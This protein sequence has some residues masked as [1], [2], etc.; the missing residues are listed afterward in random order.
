[1][2]AGQGLPARKAELG[3]PGALGADHS[4]A[5]ERA[6][7]SRDQPSV[8]GA[9]KT[10]LANV[11]RRRER[12]LSRSSSVCIAAIFMVPYLTKSTPHFTHVVPAACAW[13]Q[14]GHTTRRGW[15]QRRQ[16]CTVSPFGAPHLRHARVTALVII[17]A[18]MAGAPATP[19]FATVATACATHGRVPAVGRLVEPPAGT[20]GAESVATGI[21]IAPSGQTGRRKG[22][23][24]MT[25]AARVTA[26]FR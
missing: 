9:S 14:A 19:E 23:Q 2:H 18:A 4:P 10:A 21:S 8:T 20:T 3:E 24:A 5:S 17:R 22:R 15:W 16:N 25:G 6:Y 11:T 26:A 7:E 13:A 12:R 1:M